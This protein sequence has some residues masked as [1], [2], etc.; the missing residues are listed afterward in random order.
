MGCKRKP[1]IRKK[2]E[3]KECRVHLPFR[4]TAVHQDDGRKEDDLPLQQR[5]AAIGD[6][7]V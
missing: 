2:Q 5:A 4:R 3:R 1:D 6:D 7:R